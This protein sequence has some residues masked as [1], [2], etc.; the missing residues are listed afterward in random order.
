MLSPCVFFSLL[1]RKKKNKQT[2]SCMPPKPQPPRNAKGQFITQLGNPP[3][4]LATPSTPHPSTS[5]A[6]PSS[7]PISDPLANRNLDQTGYS[8]NPGPVPS[9]LTIPGA[10]NSMTPLHPMPSQIPRLCSTHSQPSQPFPMPPSP[11][12]PP[13]PTANNPLYLHP[14]WNMPNTTPAG[15]AAMPSARASRA[16]RFL[17][18]EDERS[19]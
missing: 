18:K 1:P 6:L 13:Q 10:F 2:P 9:R 19:T 14:V 12:L 3:S 7:T 15:P 8:S 4:S 16:L 5:R 17:G 11:N